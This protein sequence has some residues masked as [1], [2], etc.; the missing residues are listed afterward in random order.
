MSVDKNNVSTA[1]VAELRTYG[2]EVM[3]ENFAPAM[4]EEN[5]RKKVADH[6]GIDVDDTPPKETKPT[7]A[8]YKAPKP[9][10]MYASK[11]DAIA[12]KV[13]IK[14][15]IEKGEGG[16]Q[17]VFQGWNGISYL[18]KRGTEA[19]IPYG[20]YLALMD[21]VTTEYYQADMDSPMTSSD[22]QTVPV[23]L[24]RDPRA[25]ER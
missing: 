21:A 1:D 14:I 17:D 2:K 22:A 20:A 3:G 23:Q 19:D 7:A 12:D 10:K 11:A 8:R 6:L 16:D 25:G 5:I 13:T 15:P 9:G 18:I 4:K 24:V